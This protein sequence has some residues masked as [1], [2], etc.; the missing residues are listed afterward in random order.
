MFLCFGGILL[1]TLSKD[2]EDVSD[3]TDEKEWSSYDIGVIL[4]SLAALIFAIAAVTTRRLRDLHF[5]VM[6]FYLTF[7][8]LLFGAVWILFE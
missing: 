5:S 2:S 1:V 7:T 6:Q 3:G 8:S 4:A